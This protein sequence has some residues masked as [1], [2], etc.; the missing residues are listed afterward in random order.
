MELGKSNEN[1]IN[2]KLEK[3]LTD[4]NQ[5]PSYSIDKITDRIYL[6]GLNGAMDF[7]YL[8]KEKIT[9]VLSIVDIKCKYPD[10]LNITH[11]IISVEDDKNSNLLHYFKEC[12]EFIESANKI[13]IH[14]MCGISRSPAI[15]IAYLIWKTNC[16]YD[17]VYAFVQSRRTFINPNGGFVKQLKYFEKLMKINNY[18]LNV[19]EKF[20]YKYKNNDENE[21]KED[22]DEKYLNKQK[23]GNKE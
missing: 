4:K 8:S 1:E 17:D 11:K 12:I 20:I 19:I 10:N 7:N 13:Y 18:N 3:L 9:H 2:P 5:L 15:V 22:N 21:E 6:G 14:C 23:G 16:S